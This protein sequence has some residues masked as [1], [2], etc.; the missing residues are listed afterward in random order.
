MYS[1]SLHLCF[2]DAPSTLLS[3]LFVFSIIGYPLLFSSPLCV[4][5]N[6]PCSSDGGGVCVLLLTHRIWGLLVILVSTC[7]V[8]CVVISLLSPM[9][10]SI[11]ILWCPPAFICR[12]CLVFSYSICL[13]VCSSSLVIVSESPR[14]IRAVGHS[15]L[16]SSVPC[17]MTS[18]I[19]RPATQIR[20]I[21]SPFRFPALPLCYTFPVLR[22]SVQP[23][24][25]MFFVLY[26]HYVL[27]A[28][29][30]IPGSLL[31]PFK[32]FLLLFWFIY[33]RS[34]R[35][36]LPWLSWPSCHRLCCLTYY[37]IILTVCLLLAAFGPPRYHMAPQ[38]S[39]RH[40]RTPRL[41]C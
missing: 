4:C 28:L 14:L 9:A 13:A 8:L 33:L 30:L 23:F 27:L 17:Y 20:C 26:C 36:L 41:P 35:I 37:I 21:I 5:G 38:V 29:R 15:A 18:C 25:H 7:L 16:V 24:Y 34:Q 31:L 40:R 12:P 1:F 11:G 2:H 6:V 19:P 3:L 22:S 39:I 32:C 10:I